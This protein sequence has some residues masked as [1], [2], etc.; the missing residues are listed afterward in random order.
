MICSRAGT[1][2]STWYGRPGEPA[3]LFLQQV[4]STP[5]QLRVAIGTFDVTYLWPLSGDIPNNPTL[6]GLDLVF[7]SFALGPVTRKVQ[8]EFP[9]IVPS[10][11]SGRFSLPTVPL[12]VVLRTTI[13]GPIVSAP[14]TPVGCSRWRWGCCSA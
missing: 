4:D 9:E 2:L 8:D 7:Q 1:S 5:V 6:S 12:A 10:L 14:P 13:P 3:L 11:V